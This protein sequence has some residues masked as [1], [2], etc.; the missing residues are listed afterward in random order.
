ASQYRSGRFHDFLLGRSY[1][2]DVA[3]DTRAVPLSTVRRLLPGR[4]HALC[5]RSGQAGG[6]FAFLPEPDVLSGEDSG[7]LALPIHPGPAERARNGDTVVLEE[8]RAQGSS[9]LHRRT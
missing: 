9:G 8:G 6:D 3:A 5:A 2:P 1:A 4:R 7:L